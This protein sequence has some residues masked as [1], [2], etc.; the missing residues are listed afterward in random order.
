MEID[1]QEGFTVEELGEI[2][3]SQHINFEGGTPSALMPTDLVP[4]T[5][6]HAQLNV[7]VHDLEAR[8]KLLEQSFKEHCNAA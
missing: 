8:V 4:A 3:K 7:F 6:T 5:L 1:N 2:Q